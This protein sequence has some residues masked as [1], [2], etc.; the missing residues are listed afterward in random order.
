MARR[1]RPRD[2]WILRARRYGWCMSRRA[3]R[4][5]ENRMVAGPLEAAWH[6]LRG[7]HLGR[8]AR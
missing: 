7:V 4:Y 1:V 2:P 6:A 5:R 8:W 3:R